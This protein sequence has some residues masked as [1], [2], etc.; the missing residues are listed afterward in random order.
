MGSTHMSPR[1]HTHPLPQSPPAAQS[2]Q[3]HQQQQHRSVKRPRPVKSCTECRKRKLRC[4]RLCPCSQ[5][6]KSGRN[7]KYAVDYDSANLSDLSDGEIEARPAK[8]SY[9]GSIPSQPAASV[10]SGQ[11]PVRNG[12]TAVSAGS[13][14]VEELAQRMDR[15]ERHLLSRDPG[16]LR[17]ASSRPIAT[18]P[19]TLRGLTVKRGGQSTRHFGQSNPR[20]L[21]NMVCEPVA[22]YRHD[23]IDPC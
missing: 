23:T 11:G 5:C 8:R 22:E 2:A 3:A 20:V 10:E 12:E 21:L 16:H 7:C 4:D 9:V 14:F 19:A 18:D 17:L 15:M 13:G 6:Q 1:Q